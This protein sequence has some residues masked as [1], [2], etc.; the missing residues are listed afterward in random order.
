MKFYTNNTFNIAAHII[1]SLKPYNKRR[2]KMKGNKY[3][4]NNS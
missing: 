3:C 4:A 1:S 2:R